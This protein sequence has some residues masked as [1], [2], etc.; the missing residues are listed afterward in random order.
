MSLEWVE[1]GLPFSYDENDG[2]TFVST[3]GDLSL[4]D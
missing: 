3:V 2:P 1:C 4:G